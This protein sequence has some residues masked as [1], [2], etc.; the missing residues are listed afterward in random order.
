M[1]QMDKILLLMLLMLLVVEV[2]LLMQL[3]MPDLEVLVVGVAVTILLVM[4]LVEM[5]YPD[6][7]IKVVILITHGMQVAQEVEVP[8]KP[9]IML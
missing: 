5:V 6:K 2:D 1:E 7:D 8:V 9:V 4:L 3:V